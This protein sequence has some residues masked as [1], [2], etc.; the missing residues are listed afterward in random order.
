LKSSRGMAHEGITIDWRR[1]PG[2][3]LRF[4]TQT[5]INFKF[6]Q[7]GLGAVAYMHFLRDH[8]NQENGRRIAYIGKAINFNTRLRSNH[9][10][11][12][13]VERKGKTLV[14][15]GRIAFERIRH[16]DI[17][18]EQIEDVIKFCVWKNLENDK[19]F[20][21]LPGFRK[22]QPDVM[23]PW[24]IKNEGYRFSGLMPRQVAYPSIAIEF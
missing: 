14:S 1:L 18:Y 12:D 22:S 15:C 20:H 16:R 19:G 6:P 9:N 10:H 17:Y 7:D 8:K 23:V 4:G 21:S 13:L 3:D 11:F 5:K 2:R 24:F